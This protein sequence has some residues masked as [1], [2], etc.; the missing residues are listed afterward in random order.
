MATLRIFF[1][2]HHPNYGHIL[3]RK[4]DLLQLRVQWNRKTSRVSCLLL[5]LPH[6]YGIQSKLSFVPEK[7]SHVNVDVFIA[8]QGGYEPEGWRF[9]HTPGH[10]PDS[11]CILLDE[12]VLF[13]GDHLLPDITPHPSR[14]AY[15]KDE[16]RVLPLHYGRVNRIFGLMNYVRSL[17]KLMTLPS[18]GVKVTFP[19]HRLFFKGQFNLILDMRRRASDI[20]R[21]HVRRCH[22]ILKIMNSRKYNTSHISVV[23]FEPSLLKGVGGKFLAENEIFSH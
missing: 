11:I 20:I 12:E 5:A 13:T 7:C 10:T 18:E 9:I 16:Q 4:N 1:L 2:R 15:F 6:A 8:E 19:G 17:N 23:Y 21:F 14:S 22:D 3:S